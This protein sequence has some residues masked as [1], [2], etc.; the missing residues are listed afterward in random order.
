MST[1]VIIPEIVEDDRLLPQ[2]LLALREF[3]RLM[4]S[5]VAIPGTRRRVGLDAAIGLIPGIGDAVGALLA[6]WVVVGALRHRV[7]ARHVGR[8]IWNIAI[9]L[10]IGAIPFVGDIFDVFWKPN[11]G[12]VE[13]LLSHRNRMRPPRTF[14]RI[15]LAAALVLF[16]FIGL[17]IAAVIVSIVIITWMMRS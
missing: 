9:D 4:D 12:N 11:K 2:D 3:A 14:G 1:A 16:L 8:M 13:I 7:P 5:A 6:T 10:L 17:A 15:A